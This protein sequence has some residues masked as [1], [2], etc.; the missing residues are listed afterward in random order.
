MISSLPWWKARGGFSFETHH[1]V[2]IFLLDLKIN[3]F[4]KKMLVYLGNIDFSPMSV[5][6]LLYSQSLRDPLVN[7]R[8]S[9][10]TLLRSRI[11]WKEFCVL[12]WS[13]RCEWAAHGAQLRDASPTPLRLRRSEASDCSSHALAGVTGSFTPCSVWTCDHNPGLLWWDIWSHCENRDC[14][15]KINLGSGGTASNQLTGISHRE[16]GEARKMDRE[17][18]RKKQRGT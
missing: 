1:P 12:S 13:S 14:A 2:R 6:I 8:M 10:R 18:H 9:A 11:P 15:N 17:M 3:F 5:I 7:S 4:L 16:Y